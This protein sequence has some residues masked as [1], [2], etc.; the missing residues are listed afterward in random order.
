[1]AKSLKSKS[2]RSFR[3]QKREK[4][5]YAATEAAR[6]HRLNAKLTSIT[7]TPGNEVTSGEHIEEEVE[8]VSGWCW[9]ALLGILDASDITAENMAI[10]VNGVRESGGME[11][12]LEGSFL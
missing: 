12:K 10:I 11:L 1:M 6:L 5:V 3:S 2:K 8:D 4:G 9:F 7:S